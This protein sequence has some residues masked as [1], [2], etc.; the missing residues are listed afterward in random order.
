MILL[1]ILQNAAI[2]FYTAGP[3]IIL[4][5]ILSGLIWSFIIFDIK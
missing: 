1:N 5:T 3:K 4:F 2:Y